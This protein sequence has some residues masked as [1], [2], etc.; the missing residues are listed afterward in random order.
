MAALWLATED[1][2]ES[3]IPH[4]LSLARRRGDAVAETRSRDED[5]VEAVL[6][7]CPG[8]V[9]FVGKVVDVERRTAGGDASSVEVVEIDEAPLTYVPGNATLVRVKASGNL[10]LAAG[11]RASM[12]SQPE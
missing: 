9:L 5:P 3:V 10:A 4:T 1:H 6:S 8:T 11:S 7:T 2:P 12:A